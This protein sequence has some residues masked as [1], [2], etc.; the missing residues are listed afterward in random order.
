VT[1]LLDV[2]VLMPA[3]G[4]VYAIGVARVLGPR[5]VLRRSLQYALANRTLTVLGVLPAIALAI[6]LVRARNRTLSEIVTGSS[7]LYLLL[8][9]ASVAAFTYR[10]R[11]RQWLD[12]RFFR[13][14]YDARQILVSLANRVRFETDPADLASV[15]VTELD[16]ALHPQMIAI[17]VNGMEE[18][19]LWPVASLHGTVEPLPL[20][21]GLVAMLRWSDEPLEFL[22]TCSPAPAAARGTGVAG[23]L[24][25]R[26]ARPR[27]RDRRRGAGG[28][29]RGS[30]AH[31]ATRTG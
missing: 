8:V 14:E 11:A 1:G 10:E 25:R 23:V 17:L 30:P 21:G 18:N 7:G 15:V 4:L 3:F 22:G 19:R 24:W 6:S 20:D 16:E 31:R 27:F 13:E 9:A 5:I 12:Q 26:P 2:L 29:P 28:C